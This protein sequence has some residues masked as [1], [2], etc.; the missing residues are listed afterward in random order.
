MNEPSN[1]D[2]GREKT[3]T[4]H[5]SEGS[6][7]DLFN[8]YGA[9]MAQ[10]S[11]EGWSK[12]HPTKRGV[13]I[14]RSGYPGVQRHAVIWHGDN[15]AWWEHLRLA[16]DT[17]ISY[18]LCGA[19]YTG[20][21]LPGFFGNPPD[22]MA[23]RSFQIGAFLPLYRGHSYK[24][25][26]SKEPYAYGAQA[27]ELIK[28]TIK[29]RYSL[30]T[31]WYSHYERCVR[32]NLPPM[33][34][35][36]ADDGSPLRDTFM[37]FNKMLVVAVTNRDERARAIWLPDGIWY[38][39]GDTSTALQ[40]GQWITETIT[41][42]KIP[43]FVQ[44]GSI[45]VRNAPGKNVEETLKKPRRFEVYRDMEGKASGYMSE[46]DG[47]SSDESAW[48]RFQLTVDIGQHN[49]SQIALG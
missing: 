42:D 12:T 13:I 5:S 33:Q 47:I 45:L 6:F 46:D 17:C 23:L 2:G 48:K 8:L 27:S 32:L 22:D 41:F 39:L 24:L 14:T 15:Y 18:S 36:F 11:V 35:V 9:S 16:V 25:N 43:V 10:A 31:E 19:F 29:L 3:A 26:S 1:F 7:R 34:P 40:G 20:P 21:D 4:A 38:R 28:D 44:G 37:L 30:I 49:V